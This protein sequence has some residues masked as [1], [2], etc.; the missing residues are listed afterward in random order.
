[1]MTGPV[2]RLNFTPAFVESSSQQCE[3][4][5]VVD[6]SRSMKGAYINASSGGSSV[7][8]EKHTDRMS[9][10]RHWLRFNLQAFV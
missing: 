5:F 1:M 3:L 10:Q 2:V 4:V 9:F 8:P 7:V 6:R